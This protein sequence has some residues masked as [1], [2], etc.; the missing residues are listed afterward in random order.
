MKKRIFLLNIF[1]FLIIFP[2]L[3]QQNKSIPIGRQALIEELKKLEENPILAKSSW[4]VQ[5][6]NVKS[7]EIIIESNAQKNL[8][9]ASVMKAI[10]TGVAFVRLGSQYRFKTEFY[11]DGILGLDSVLHGNLIVKGYGDPTFGS[12]RWKSTNADSLFLEIA[13]EL[14]KNRINKIDGAIIADISSFDIHQVSPSWQWGDIGNHYGA[15]ASALNFN[16]NIYQVF[17]K[18]G[19]LVGNKATID[20]ILP[21]LNNV[22]IQNNVK[23]GPPRSGDN[24]NIYADHF[25]G[26]CQ[27]EGTVPMD[28][29]SFIVKGAIPQPEIAFIN[30]LNNALQSFGIQTSGK[31]SKI[32]YSS[33]IDTT[34]LQ[35]LFHTI[36]SP[37]LQSI[38]NITNKNSHNTFAEAIFKAIGWNRFSMGSFDT[39]SSVVTSFLKQ[40]KLDLE[41]IEIR[42]GSGLSRNNL[43]S[44]D[45]LCTFFNFMY[46]QKCFNIYYETL[47]EAGES[48]TL[49][50]LFQ[51]QKTKVNIR[52]KSGTMNGIRSYGGYAT[53]KK[54]ELLSF[55]IIINHFST[56]SSDI[57]NIMEQLMLAISQSE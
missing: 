46:T 50:R 47:S 29:K 12:H 19:S 55:A 51:K 5:V 6:R 34:K 57:R 8:V 44:A 23:T 30:H 45:F 28:S 49:R 27:M 25:S 24:V 52:A 21:A 37:S 14:K 38:V 32:S 3:G 40:Q 15:G 1:C 18:P 41:G 20:S 7:G 42:D 16:E 2:I 11:Y 4:S 10:T 54:G 56:K 31:L 26:N 13:Q 35:T 36:Y 9:P 53:N 33:E 17:F 22:K 48:G 43:I 39:G